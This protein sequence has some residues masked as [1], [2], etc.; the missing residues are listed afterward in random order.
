[1]K[2][3]KERLNSWNQTSSQTI[4]LGRCKSDRITKEWTKTTKE[5][6][7]DNPETR[8]G[9]LAEEMVF[10]YLSSA[11]KW[12]TWFE[13]RYDKQVAGIDFQ[14][15][16]QGWANFYTADV[17]ANLNK[18]KFLVYPDE[19]SKKSNDRMIH[20]DVDSGWAVE[21]SRESMISYIRNLPLH[22]DKKGKRYTL[23]DAFNP[24]VRQRVSFFRRFPLER[25]SK[26]KLSEKDIKLKQL[27]EELSKVIN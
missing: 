17:K 15:K 26:E 25:V 19:I 8:K 23:L 9:Y 1:M 14:F 21:Y 22:L 18:G 11:Y 10:K 27:E 2:V 20:V 4:R 7:G 6:F 3:Y 16:K 5:A 13:D 12:V 24:E